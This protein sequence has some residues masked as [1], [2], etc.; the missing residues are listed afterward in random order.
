[1]SFY[2]VSISRFT[3]PMVKAPRTLT[4]RPGGRMDVHIHLSYIK[5]QGFW[6]LVANCLDIKGHHP[7]FN[8]IDCLL[9]NTK[10]THAQVVDLCRVKIGGVGCLSFVVRDYMKR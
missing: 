1:M 8:E 3:G 2:T 9:E 6:S 10:I 4:R 7:L 5:P